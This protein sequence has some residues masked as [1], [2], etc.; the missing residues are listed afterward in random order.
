MTS[1]WWEKNFHWVET[2]LCGLCFP[3]A[4]GIWCYWAAITVALSVS[5]MSVN[6]QYAAVHSAAKLWLSAG[7]VCLVIFVVVCF[8]KSYYVLL[9]SNLWSFYSIRLMSAGITSI[10]Y[11]DSRNVLLCILFSIYQTITLS[12][13]RRYLYGMIV[14]YQISLL[15]R[16]PPSLDW[17][18]LYRHCL[19]QNCLF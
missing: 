14:L 19:L 2:L 12:Q 13:V 9:F 5:I 11:I 6:S 4:H 1:W 17:F 7:Q 16:F 18:S 15:Q 8:L 3:W 10:S